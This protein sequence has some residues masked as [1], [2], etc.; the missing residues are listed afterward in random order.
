MSSESRTAI[1]VGIAATVLIAATKFTAGGFS[2]SSAMIAEGMHSL[3]DT[4][5]G[6]L[7]LYGQHRA[8]RAPDEQHPL[9]HG[10]ELYFW[11]LIVSL[12]F[13]ALGG[14]M[15]FYEGVQHLFHPSALT[16]PTWNYIV[17]VASAVFT[18]GSF[19]VALRAFRAK[20]RGRSYWA[21]FRQSKDPTLFTLALED[22]A[23]LLGLLIAALG[24]FLSH[25]YH[26][27]YL[28]AVAS[29]GV[30]LV[31]AAVAI[32]LARESK[33]LLV[34]EGASPRAIAA[35]TQVVQE[36]RAVIAVR[37]PVTMYFGPRNALLA[38]DVEF[39]ADL[40]SLEIA[41]AVDRLEARIRENEPDVKHI[42]IE[43]EALR[44]AAA[45]QRGR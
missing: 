9:G 31:L 30:G 10:K 37:R 29:M 34:G 23:D 27:S 44:Q 2:G 42:Y 20:R 12:L 19:A 32:L 11:A 26:S 33:G 16:D 7:L 6:L 21:T 15:S 28:D 4:S 22:I 3:V 38:M 18:L 43:A 41:A 35:I 14:G 36:D 5:D 40:T 8:A 24:V 39:R 25:K 45:Q 1:Y 13:F 17:L